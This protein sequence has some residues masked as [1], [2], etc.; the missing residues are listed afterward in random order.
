MCSIRTT[1]TGDPKKP[2]KLKSIIL[3]TNN[4]TNPIAIALNVKQEITASNRKGSFDQCSTPN[5]IQAT[6]MQFTDTKDTK[7][8][9]NSYFKSNECVQ[10]ND[11][12]RSYSPPLPATH[13]LT[14]TIS[15]V[16]SHQTGTN[17]ET[18]AA[19]SSKDRKTSNKKRKKRRR[20][21]SR[22]TRSKSR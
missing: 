1:A 3:S 21:Y 20:S 7:P 22:D 17:H 2:P 9:I 13:R 11:V 5:K 16:D 18:R 14:S 8:I 6:D 10:Q 19:R 15:N 12:Q 4:N